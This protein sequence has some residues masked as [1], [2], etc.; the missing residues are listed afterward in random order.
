M[1]IEA[2]QGPWVDALAAAGYQ[3]YAINPRAVTRYRDRHHISGAKSDAS[4]AKVLAP[5]WGRTGRHDHRPIADDSFEDTHGC[6]RHHTHYDGHRAWVHR[7]AAA[8]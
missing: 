4:D 5:I 8:A 2:D 6:L 1:A 3:V 7:T